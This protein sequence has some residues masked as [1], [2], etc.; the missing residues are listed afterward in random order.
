MRTGALRHSE[1]RDGVVQFRGVLSDYIILMKPGIVGL[2]LV[3]TL[4]GIYL[5]SGGMVAPSL[6]FWTLA[7]VGLATAGSAVL[8]NYTDRD[9]DPL[10][11]RTSGRALARGT[12][13]EKNALGFGLLLV[14]L[15]MTILLPRVNVLTA[16]LT[17]T[18][19]FTYVVLYGMVLKRRT[20]FANQIGGL[21][22][23]LPPVLGWTAVT[24]TIGVEASALFVMMAIW[25]QPHALS[26][27]LK[28]RDDYRKASIPVVPVVC[29]VNSTKLRILLYTVALL[30]ISM[31]P[32]F[33]G[34]SGP[35]Y[36]GITAVMGVVYIVLSLRFHLS[37]RKCS[38]FLFFY[39]IIYLTV[40]FTA[41]VLNTGV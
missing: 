39:S 5:A 26:L 37:E 33:L 4:S 24:G 18:A 9:I 35:V 40:I 27:A 21:S 25:Q 3:S 23:A 29:G 6:L 11:K 14:A 1:A 41:M 34:T 28:Y 20:S 38:M 13:S 12:I 19:T 31:L 10:M 36:L 7:G 16:A 8:N 2:V 15:S 30:P 22:G 32:Y 17:A